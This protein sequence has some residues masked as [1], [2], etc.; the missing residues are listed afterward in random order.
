M[1]NIVFESDDYVVV[2]DRQP[3]SVNEAVTILNAGG[4]IECNDFG[5]SVFDAGYVTSLSEIIEHN[6]PD[7]NLPEWL[8]HKYLY[9]Y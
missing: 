9:K 8:R 7:V 1:A 2:D 3:I 6:G 4:K 5:D